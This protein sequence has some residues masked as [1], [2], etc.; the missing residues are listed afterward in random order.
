MDAPVGF[1]KSYLVSI[2]GITRLALIV[3]KVYL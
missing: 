3:I 1:N 2:P